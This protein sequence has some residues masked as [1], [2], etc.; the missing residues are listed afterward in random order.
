MCCR[1]PSAPNSPWGCR[2]HENENY[3]LHSGVESEQSV[4]VCVCVCV[5]RKRRSNNK[6]ETL[7]IIYAYMYYNAQREQLRKL[8]LKT[9]A[10]LA[11]QIRRVGSE[12]L[13]KAERTQ[14]R[15]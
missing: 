6:R 8:G 4:R 11:L 12:M 5:T 1:I 3:V 9:T 10:L 13:Q 14:A 15:K 7:M 2:T